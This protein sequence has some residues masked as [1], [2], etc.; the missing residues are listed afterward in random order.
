MGF[1]ELVT[2]DG[3][4]DSVQVLL[5]GV[6]LACLACRRLTST[7]RAEVRPAPLAAFVDEVGL[8][9]LRQQTEQA[10]AAIE[11]VVRA[12]RLQ[13]NRWMAPIDP[14]GAGAAADS[15]PSGSHPLSPGRG[16]TRSGRRIRRVA[17]AGRRG[18]DAARACR[19]DPHAGR[20]DRAG[21]QA[22]AA[23][24]LSE[25]GG[26]RQNLPAGAR[27]AAAGAAGTRPAGVARG[28]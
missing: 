8:Q 25:R 22:A 20:R 27:R 3:V 23:Q 11:Q 26:D 7:C 18:P 15:E 1:L 6:V 14:G 12:E 19:P 2:V 24:R 17:P 4:R 9:S 5:C 13:L 16:R 10:L 21:A 28:W